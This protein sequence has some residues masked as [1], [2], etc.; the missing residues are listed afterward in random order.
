MPRFPF[1]A[2]PAWTIGAMLLVGCQSAVEPVLP[3]P[4]PAAAPSLSFEIS[5][6]SQIDAT[7]LFRWEAIAFGGSGEYLYRWEVTR[8]GA[9]EVTIATGRRLALLVA[10]TD[11]DVMLRLTVTSGD[12]TRVA[13]FGVRNC[14][15]VCPK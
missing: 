13:S 5:G 6:P 4:P 14:I 10:D 11:G 3:A 15:S 7:G 9:G 8:Q 1:P 12:Q 2:L